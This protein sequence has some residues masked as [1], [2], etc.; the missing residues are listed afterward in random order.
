MLIVPEWMSAVFWPMLFLS[1]S[2]N[3][4]F[5]LEVCVLHKSNVVIHSGKNGENLFSSTPNT[6][7]LAIRVDFQVQVERVGPTG[8]IYGLVDKR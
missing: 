5:I 6:N 1:G 4:W 3:S 2:T 7:L 8:S